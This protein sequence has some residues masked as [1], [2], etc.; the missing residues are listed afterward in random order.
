MTSS[1][2]EKILHP[3]HR[4][5]SA[6]PPLNRK[7]AEEDFPRAT[8]EEPEL[9][10]NTTTHKSGESPAKDDLLPT[11]DGPPSQ[12]PHESST[13]DTHPQP[14]REYYPPPP[15]NNQTAFGNTGL[16]AGGIL[17]AGSGSSVGGG[18]L[19]GD[20]L[21]TMIGQRVHQAQNHAY[22]RERAMMYNAGDKNAVAAPMGPRT[23]RAERREERRRE[24]WE[25]RAARRG[26]GPVSADGQ[27]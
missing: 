26:D 3:H 5:H 25:R 4:S 21:G 19:E 1:F 10:P 9:M 24:R 23:A 18:M 13:R 17:A 12:P 7:I 20:V 16:L 8:S 11:Y 22:W 27:A 2:L 15:I 6:E 14:H